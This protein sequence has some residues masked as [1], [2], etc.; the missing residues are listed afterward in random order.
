MTLFSE[1]GY[2]AVTVADVARLAGVSVATVFNYFE[3]KEDLFFDESALLLDALVEAVRACPAGDSILRALQEQVVGQLTA[4][5]AESG[6]DEVTR[7]HAAVVDSPDL[8]RH[9]Q[10]LQLRR[11]YALAAALA[12][13]LGTGRPSLVADVAAAQYLAAESVIGAELRTRLLAG[14]PLAT[15]LAE[16][17]P[18]TAEVFATLHSG[19]G[20]LAK[21]GAPR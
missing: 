10:H 17:A 18:L 7:F 11:R 1:R 20:P 9:E 15:A 12:D 2:D 3:T 8:Q 14:Q 13:A 4:G 19:L 21:A 5:R 16:L 6:A